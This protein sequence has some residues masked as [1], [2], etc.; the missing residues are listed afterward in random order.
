MVKEDVKENIGRPFPACRA[1]VVDENMN[2]VPR[3]VP[4]ELIIE[5]QMVGVGYHNRPEQQAK[6]FLEWPHP[7]C[8]AYRTGDL[9]ELFAHR[10]C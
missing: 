6:A 5:G 1:Y 4:G 9:G 8:R 10:S 3:S 7:G 2:V